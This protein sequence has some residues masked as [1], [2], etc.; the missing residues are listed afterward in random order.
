MTEEKEQALTQEDPFEIGEAPFIFKDKNG[1]EWDAT[2]TLGGAR[3][4]DASDFTEITKKRFSILVPEK[5]MFI[6]VLS[7]SSLVFAMI[8]AINQDRVQDNLGIDP[9]V[10]PEEAE[11]A[12]LDS[13]DGPT[14]QAGKRAFWGALADFFPEHKT[15][16]LTLILQL[17]KTDAKIALEIKALIP[18]LER[19]MNKEIKVEV[20]KARE[21]LKK[22]GGKSSG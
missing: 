17:A 6:E 15:A 1:K 13:L 19:V 3:R 20:A 7:N 16:L 18:D 5:E 14:I 22:V 4:I 10:K 9:K 21:D 11:L 12:F 8:W 2:L